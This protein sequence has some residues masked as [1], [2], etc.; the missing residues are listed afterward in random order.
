MRGQS[1]RDA[2]WRV[3][4]FLKI[5]CNLVVNTSLELMTAEP[6]VRVVESR[7]C[8]VIQFQTIPMRVKYPSVAG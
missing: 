4:F 6:L 8:D 3:F 7:L 5:L 2:L 1:L